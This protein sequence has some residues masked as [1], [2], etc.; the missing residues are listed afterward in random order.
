MVL[1]ERRRGRRS[2]PPRQDLVRRGL[3]DEFWKRERWRTLGFASVDDFQQGL[4]EPYFAAMDPDD[5]LRMAWSC[6]AAT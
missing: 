1:L 3:L 2:G 4:M 5:L 6:N